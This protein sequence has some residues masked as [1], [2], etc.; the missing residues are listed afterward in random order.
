[1]WKTIRQLHALIHKK[2]FFYFLIFLTILGGFLEILG[3]SLVVPVV[4]AITEPN[5]IQTNYYLHQCYIL[6]NSKS[7]IHFIMM[8]AFVI[9][10][11]YCIKLLYHIC[12][13]YLQSLFSYQISLNFTHQIFSRYLYIP[14]ESLINFSTS[15]LIN[16]I[17]HAAHMNTTLFM[18]LFI[19]ISECIIISLIIIVLL[20]VAPILS[21]GIFILCILGFLFIYLPVQKYIEKAGEQC[22]QNLKTIFSYLEN[23]L[24]NIK[25]VKITNSEKYFIQKHYKAEKKLGKAVLASLTISNIPRFALETIAVVL[26]MSV[27]IILLYQGIPP[28]I[29]AIYATS[30][31]AIMFRLIPSF[32]R[33][34][35]NLLLIRNNSYLLNLIYETIESIPQET[36]I[37]AD[38]S[39]I[40]FHKKIELQNCTFA[41]NNTEKYILKN[42]NL[43]INKLETIGIIGKTGA[44]KTTLIDCIIGFLIPQQGK[45]LVDNKDIHENIHSWRSQIGYV[46]QTIYLSNESI[47]QNIAFATPD[48]NIDEKHL[49]H[50]MEMAQI[51]EYVRT[52]PEKDYTEVGDAGVRL[53]GGQRQRIAIARA[54]YHSPQLLILDEATSSLD[55]D[56]ERAFIDA[57]QYLKGKITILIIAH[58]KSSLTYCDKII[59]IE[60]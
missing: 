54:L 3:L 12:L 30:V 33:I 29:L 35:Y 57:L 25:E 34:H 28:S 7:N 15:D 50:V 16:R 60:S 26:I 13:I 55:D 49:W 32:S 42:F 10:V 43:T 1:M 31:V 19:V 36:E 11:V 24:Y 23:T 2:I 44:G 47:R 17:S 56:T 48:E 9:A 38:A 45:I 18:P 37:K 20:L 52:L 4:I 27:I 5:I 51:A 40:T 39:P 59:S 58:R 46:S 53:S 41:Y 22:V 8:I 14:Y 21:L 6:L